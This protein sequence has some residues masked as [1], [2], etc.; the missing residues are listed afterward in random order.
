MHGRPRQHAPVFTAVITKIIF[1]TSLIRS[2][3]LPPFT[4]TALIVLAQDRDPDNIANRNPK[5]TQG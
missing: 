1:L 5:G 3:F 4:P 2:P